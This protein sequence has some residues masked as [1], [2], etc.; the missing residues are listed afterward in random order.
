MR[1]IPFFLRKN[2]HQWNILP[3]D[4][5]VLRENQA[6]WHRRPMG[7]ALSANQAESNR[8]AS[9][10]VSQAS[11]AHREH[12]QLAEGL[13]AHRYAIRQ[14]GKK[15]PSL[16]LPGRRSRMVDLMSP[17]PN[18]LWKL[19]ARFGSFETQIESNRHAEDIVNDGA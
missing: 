3:I 12:L 1:R 19:I 18:Q 8:S 16:R 9:A 13:Q 5:G 2:L 14:T 6:H 11:L 7:A 17:D 10:S 15:L 4:N